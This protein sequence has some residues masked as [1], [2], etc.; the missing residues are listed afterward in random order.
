MRI[1]VDAMGGDNG[2]SVVV[3]G[4]IEAIL[5]KGNKIE[6]ILIVGKK[7]M[8][9]KELDK[10]Q[11]SD[12]PI[13]IIH[14]SEVIEMEESPAVA[15]RTKKDSSIVV[16]MKL[17]KEKKAEAIISPGNTGA[18]MASAL[19]NL[20][21]LEGIARPAIATLIPTNKGMSVLLDV[22]ANVDC[23]PKHL[24]QFALMGQVYAKYILGIKSP[25]IGLLS[26]GEE[27]G[28]G[29]GLTNATYDLL[30]STSLNFIGNVEGRDIIN[31]KVD[32]VICDGFVGNVVIKF[33]E[34]LVETILE[35][36]KKEISKSFIQKLG[37]FFLRPTFNALKK[38][39]D[40]QEYGGAPLMGVKGNCIIC[41][42]S[43]TS[44][45][46]QSALKMASM[47]VKQEVSNHIEESVKEYSGV[48]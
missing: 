39:L 41:H 13:Q 26:V 36:L 16:A 40:H 45:S 23:K 7:E 28:K 1:I 48:T 3:E 2:P 35:F 30:K 42:G 43:S 21:R 33:A 46:I 44:K 8:L 29:C 34:S 14:A 18:V 10:R 22:G 47:F 38:K 17:L 15:V 19:L 5:E 31:G 9:I 12:L 11:G 32:V 20:G 25:S 4:V 6:E 24:F 37:A 27:K